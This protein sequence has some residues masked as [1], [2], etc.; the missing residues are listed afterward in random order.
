MKLSHFFFTLFNSNKC[1]GYRKLHLR[2]RKECYYH[3]KMLYYHLKP[4]KN[5]IYSSNP[6]INPKICVT[7]VF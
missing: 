7:I 2:S 5:K 4:T 1:A 6:L 3:W